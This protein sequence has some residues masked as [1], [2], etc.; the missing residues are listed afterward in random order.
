LT[1]QVTPKN[2]Q[3]VDTLLLAATQAFSRLNPYFTL[4]LFTGTFLKF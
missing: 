3:S 4:R 2:A 1:I